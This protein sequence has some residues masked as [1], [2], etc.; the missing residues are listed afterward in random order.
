MARRRFATG[1]R[2][3]HRPHGEWLTRSGPER[4][5]QVPAGVFLPGDAD[6]MARPASPSPV[7]R[8]SRLVAVLGG[9]AGNE[10]RRTVR[11]RSTDDLKPAG[12]EA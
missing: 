6:R 11:S 1:G 7:P 8:R 2:P 3:G 5:L 12:R 4:N 10:A 9:T